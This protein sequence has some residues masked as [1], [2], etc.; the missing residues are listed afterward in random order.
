[1]PA[2]DD[3]KPIVGAQIIEELRLLAGHLSGKRVLHVNSTAVGG[4]VAEILS[5]MTPLLKELGVDARWDV[6]KGGSEFFEVTKKFHNA[7]HGRP[8]EI[9]QH[10]FDIFMET[11]QDNIN[12]VDIYGDIVF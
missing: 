11:S 5:R 4:G 2:L 12:E 9:T 10:D 1:M 6:I 3:Y 8:A 7:L